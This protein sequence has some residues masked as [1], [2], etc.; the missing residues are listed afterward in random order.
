MDRGGGICHCHCHML[1]QVQQQKAE[2]S[3]QR[4]ASSLDLS[5]HEAGTTRPPAAGHMR[6]GARIRSAP[7]ALF[8]SR[9]VAM[10]VSSYQPSTC[11]AVCQHSKQQQK[12]KKK[13]T[14]L[15]CTGREK[16]KRLLESTGPEQAVHWWELHVDCTQLLWEARCHFHSSRQ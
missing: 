13:D 1:N 2:S 9:N 10:T 6:T 15:S 12:N 7:L 14:T 5:G 4:A 11:I 3:E 8:V 16:R